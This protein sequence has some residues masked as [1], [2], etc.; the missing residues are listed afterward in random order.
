MDFEKI[1]FEKKG[2]VA[3]VRINNQEKR[4][5]LDMVVRRE[6]GDAIEIADK[7]EEIKVIV[8]TG[9]G[10]SFCAGGDIKDWRDFDVIEGRERI[11][12]IQRPIEKIV[13]SEKPVIAMVRGHAV[14]AGLSL[15]LACD[16]VI[17]SEDARFGAPFVRMG[18]VPDAGGLFFLPRTVGI[19]KAKE[20]FF[21][22]E[23]IDVKEAQRIGIVNRVVPGDSLEDEVMKLAVKIADGPSVAIGMMKAI[24]NDCFNQNLDTIFQLETNSQSLCFQTHDFKEGRDSFL[25]KREPKF[26]GR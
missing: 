22:G 17:A 20:L 3:F 10:K 16:M 12:A 5:A 25:Q 13:K 1:I 18:L 2:R 26:I 8:I 23:M 6:L 7:D 4:N 21:T 19:F 15:I 24:I 11:K 14:G 9:E